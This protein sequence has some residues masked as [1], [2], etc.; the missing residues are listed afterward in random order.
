MSDAAR[1]ELLSIGQLAQATGISIDAIRVWERRYGRP[2]SVRLPSGHRRY[3]HEQ[4]RWL[5]RVAEALAAGHR[6]GKIVGLT[7]E[8][9]DSLL[10]AAH[11]KTAF[12][13]QT[14][15]RIELIR[16]YDRV[17]LL[18]SF[19]DQV[20]SEGIP[21][22]LD[23]GLPP[24]LSA[25]G[26]CWADGT[27]QVRHEH[28]GSE[29]LEDFLRGLKDRLR[30]TTG[31]PAVILTT[32]P[33]ERHSLGLHM[34]TVHA[35]L[36][37]AHPILLG[38]ETPESEIVAACADLRAVT[39]GVSVSLGSGGV[40]TD[41]ALASLREA[42][43]ASIPLVAGGRG[44]RGV[45]RGRKGILYMRDFVSFRSFIKELPGNDGDAPKTSHSLLA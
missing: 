17:G 41:R 42:L 12:D 24:L 6:P 36:A 11:S 5:R 30:K 23:E 7:E 22:F 16:T 32:L 19:E 45:R 9:L 21:H 15:E 20:G 1:A 35:M 37:G 28:F 39:V 13:E 27:L 33:G 4:V 3:T 2:V 8:E 43:P 25:L 10:T 26:R 18:R 38:S 34:A 14:V 40:Q 31:G 44:A 29:V